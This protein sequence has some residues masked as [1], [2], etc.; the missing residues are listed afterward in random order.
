MQNI[1]KYLIILVLSSQCTMAQNSNN[2]PLGTTN[3]LS[4]LKAV[5]SFQDT[6]ETAFKYKCNGDIYC[7]SGSALDKQYEVF[8]NKMITYQSDMQ[9][10]FNAKHQAYLDE[11][12][13][14]G[15]YQDQMNLI[16]QNEIIQSMGGIEKIKSMTEDQREI[17]AK[18][19][20]ANQMSSMTFSP[21]SEAEMKRMMSD[22]AYAK[23]MT[24][25]YN[26]LSEAQKAALVKGKTTTMDNTISNTD[27][28]QQM[29]Q[30]RTAKNVIDVNTFINSCTEKM[31]RALE[32]FGSKL[33]SLRIS[34]GNHNDLDANFELE[35]QNIPLVEM[36]EGL[37]PDPY[38]TKVLRR[39][40]AEK[41]KQRAAMELELARSE[42]KQ[43]GVVIN[44]AIS[45]YYSYLDKNQ[46][47][48]NGS[49]NALYNGTNTEMSLAQLEL[50]IATTIEELARLSFSET[51]IASGHEQHYQR[52]LQ[53]K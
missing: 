49:M 6:P 36:G 48:I 16:N 5:P 40:Y 41:H 50:G 35:Y 24:A 9:A 43:L 4:L 22:P 39:N 32:T 31:A 8:K 7:Q 45:E 33:N 14:D 11:K 15:I 10:V 12:G 20:V 37:I 38:K 26:S 19:A 23:Q 27:F 44:N 30:A 52:V 34:K 1:V 18:N 51:S 53:E 2:S 13:T 17:A 46:Y 29:E 3:L 25:K 28:E 42:F 21:F 47:R